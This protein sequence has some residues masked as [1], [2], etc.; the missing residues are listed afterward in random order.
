VAKEAKANGLLEPGAIEQMLRAELQ[1]RRTD[2]FFAAA[3]LLAAQNAPAMSNDEI[4]AEIA[5]ARADRRTLN[6]RSC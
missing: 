2:G 6:A 3:D 4:E 1:R 5:A